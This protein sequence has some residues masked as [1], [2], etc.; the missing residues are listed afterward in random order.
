[1]SVVDKLRKSALRKN[2]WVRTESKSSGVTE[3]DFGTFEE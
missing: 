3:G 2:P 1:M